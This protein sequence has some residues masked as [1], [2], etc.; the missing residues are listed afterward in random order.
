MVKPVSKPIDEISNIDESARVEKPAERRASHGGDKYSNAFLFLCKRAG[1]SLENFIVDT[2]RYEKSIV[3]RP[4]EEGNFNKQYFA[5]LEGRWH[6]NTKV[7]SF[8]KNKVVEQAKAAQDAEEQQVL[9]KIK[10]LEQE[11]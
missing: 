7:W 1:I 4:P 5:T 8:L 6:Q 10:K 2:N 3:V 9:D 11:N